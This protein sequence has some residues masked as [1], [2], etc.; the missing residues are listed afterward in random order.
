MAGLAV[1]MRFHTLLASCVPGPADV[2]FRAIEFILRRGHVTQ[3]D[4]L[5]L[6]GRADAHFRLGTS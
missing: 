4:R 5:V 1:A 2:R 3:G 6:E